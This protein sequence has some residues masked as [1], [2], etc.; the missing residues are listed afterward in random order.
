MRADDGF[1]SLSLLFK[2]LDQGP[3]YSHP[4]ILQILHA[5][6]A[7]G[8]DLTEQRIRSHLPV[9]AQIVARFTTGPLWKDAALVLESVLKAFPTPAH[10]ESGAWRSHAPSHA[11][12][13]PGFSN[14]PGSGIDH[15]LTELMK[16]L[17]TCMTSSSY[18]GTAKVKKSPSAT[19][20]V[21]EKFFSFHD[22]ALG[23]TASSSSLDVG[24]VARSRSGEEKPGKEG[25]DEDKMFS[26][27]QLV[28]GSRKHSIDDT[29][30]DSVQV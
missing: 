4:P 16:V 7:G 20:E 15:T 9:W 27:G 26:P 10:V 1:Q 19:Y 8:L 5:L 22:A 12:S 6:M 17:A 30:Q 24:S 11:S 25:T 13:K 2:I 23:R 18:G 21:F 29:D 14:K 28:Y 3:T